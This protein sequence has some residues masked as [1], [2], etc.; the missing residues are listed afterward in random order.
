MKDV[1]V[2]TVVPRL[3]ERLNPLLEMA[4]NLWFSWNLEGIDIFR[5]VDQTLWDETN[6]NPLAILGRLGEDRIKEILED[7]GFLQE[8]DRIYGDFRRYMDNK[9]AYD[10]GLETP[11]VFTIAYFS[12]EFGLTDSLPIYSGGLGVLAGDHLKTASDLRVPVVA[13]GLFY[14]KGYFRQY[15]NPDGWQQEVYPD[16]DFHNL[17]ATLERGENDSPLTI[18]VPIQNRQVKV[19]IWRIGVG[20]VPLFMLDTNNIENSDQDRDITASLYGGDRSMRL[21]Q[22][23]VLGIGGVRALDR[24]GYGPSVFHMNEGHSALAILERIRLLMTRFQLS[25]QEAREAVY[26]S[27]VFTTH[28]PIPAGI[29]IFDRSLITTYLGDYLRS[30][31]ISL[32]A[33]L[34]LGSEDSN[35]GDSLNMAVLALKNSTKTNGVSELHQ[36]VSRRMWRR[37]WPALPETDIPIERV[38]NGIHIPSWIS[39]DMARLFDRYLGRKWAE[40]PDNLKVWE[41]VNRIPDA[42][43]WRTHERRRERLVSFTRARLQEQLARRGAQRVELQ[44]ASEVLNPEALTIGFG[45]R[46]A[47]Y[48]RGNL[49]LKDPAHL[50]RILN[51]PKR[52]VQIIFS[53]KA[54]PQDAPGKEVIKEIVHLAQQPEFRH[55]MAFIEDYDMNVARYMVQGCDIWLNN[56]LRPQ[57]ACGTSGMKAAANGALN[58]SVLDGWWAEGY[59]PGLG[60]AIGAGEEYEDREYQDQVESQAIYDILERCAVPCFYDRGKDNLPRGWISSMKN[61]MRDLVAR[62]SGHRMMQD[63]IHGFYL[64]VAIN[65]EKISTEKFQAIRTFSAWVRKMK[66]N[67]SQIRILEKCADLKGVLHVGETVK[68]EVEMQLGKIL[69]QELAVDI[70]Y[71][72]VDSK[73]DF[74]DREIF[75]LHDFVVEGNCTTFRGE[76]PCRRVGRFG[77][78]VR[79]LPSH[80]LLANPYSLGL[81]HWG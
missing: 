9:M 42:E 78:R 60:W 14:Q 47:T 38:T 28:T 26:A 51:D 29:D 25:F 67:W 64:P 24:L 52:P 66:E 49:I 22:E 16:N 57:E 69:P 59:K 45:R 41:R 35:P 72:P 74:L 75:S 13:I 65:W 20:R 58:V 50:A 30:L 71:G 36:Q 27:N 76:I 8:M 68:I 17:P 2:Y 54:H 5:S 79:V 10:F 3:P 43:L 19:R 32:E 70:Y 48:K 39:N 12:A 37:I 4:K 55:K 62:F 80:L 33:F 73:A 44:A 46:F 56:P 7:D 77:L 40:D 53:G 81:I 11:L 23:I 6:H 31:G 63:Y 1:I 61:S 15:L 21:K 34:A 18:D